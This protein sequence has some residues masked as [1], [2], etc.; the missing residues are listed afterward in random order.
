MS[1]G[2]VLTGKD[3][4]IT[5]LARVARAIGNGLGQVT[6]SA[7]ARERVAAARAVVERAAA[8][9]QPIYGLNT[10][11]GGN[12]KYRLAPEQITGFQT[13]FVVGRA[14]GVGEPLPR[15]V[16]RAAMLARANAMTLGGA[17]VSPAVLDL[18]I[19]LINRDVT[20]VVP[21][22]GSIGAGDLGLLAHIALVV[23]GRGLAEH[24]GRVLPGDEALRAAGLSLATLG[25]KDGLAL[26]N[27]NA[28]SA[29]MAGLAL[30]TARRL[31][32]SSE[33]AAALSFEGYAA[34]PSIFDPRLAAAHPAFG[35][36]AAAQRF[37]ELIAGSSLSDAGSARSIQDALSFRCLSHVHGAAMDALERAVAACELE[38]NAAADNPL[39]LTADD[40]ML[41]TGNFH[42]MALALAGDTL[43]MA[44]SSVAAMA[45]GRIVK[46]MDADF[47][48][49]PRYLS[50]VGGASAGLVSMQKTAVALYGEIRRHAN[51]AGLDQFAVSE[52]VED[53]SAQA[54]L[55]YAKL[56]DQLAAFERLVAL[57]MLVAAQAVDLRR[58]ARLSASSAALHAAIRAA[59]PTLHE[60]RES[61]ADVEKIVGLLRAGPVVAS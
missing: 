36:V 18:L 42:L 48:Q 49:L 34:N 5:T 43:A 20:P 16:V 33:Q 39:V 14:I 24:D 53:H 55:V 51:P 19:E 56:T 41:S 29:G 25:P 2:T 11:L 35:Q 31:L 17:G 52:T 30:E 50:P 22:W 61:G 13:Q 8:G 12:L 37:R 40:E 26:C 60:D 45:V 3:L 6:L 7:E 23:I 44:L 27:G 57:E 32:R 1:R 59:V 4:D 46:L 21:R 15:A 54:P 38:L 28:L 9:E 10:G 58:P 47:T